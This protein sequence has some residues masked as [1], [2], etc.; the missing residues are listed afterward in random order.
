MSI[1]Q[2]L[3]DDA[4]SIVDTLTQTRYQHVD[5]IHPDAGVYNCD[6]NGFAF[7]VLSAVA[8]DHAALIPRSDGTRPL[9]HEYF[10]FFASLTPASPGAWRRI[11][12]LADAA[13]GDIMA[14]RF[15]T[16]E[17]DQD[18]GHVVIVAEPA[19]LDP[20]G[21]FLVLRVYDSAAKAHFQDTRAPSGQPSAKGDTGVGSG[22]INLRVD[23]AGRP[24]AYLFA[25]PST[26][27]YAYRPIA[28]GRAGTILPA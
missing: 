28:I 22:F 15:P 2:H 10:E 20:S 7:H 13:R 4:Q 9:A 21:A 17:P 6:C 18:T 8:P 5:D 23:G 24:L 1:P 19:A 16:L 25:P 27:Q 3:A 14:W 12:R 11:D 26:A